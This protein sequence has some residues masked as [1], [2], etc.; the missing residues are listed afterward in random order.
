MLNNIIA[1]IAISFV[2]VGVIWAIGNFTH[3][4]KVSTTNHIKGI[5]LVA[6]DN[7]FNGT[8]PDIIGTVNVPEKL[9]VLNKDFVRHDLIVDKLNINTAYLSPEQDFTTAIA[10]KTSGIFEYYCSL[11]PITM[12]GKIVIKTP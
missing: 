6:Q 8:N 10:S 9:V 3:P 5:L 12:R 1:I 4:A 2:T 11:H 7:L